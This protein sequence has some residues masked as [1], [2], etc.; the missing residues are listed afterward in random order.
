MCLH[1]HYTY[2]NNPG[3]ENT[4]ARIL[5]RLKQTSPFKR[6]DKRDSETCQLPNAPVA[7]ALRPQRSHAQDATSCLGCNI[8]H[9]R[10]CKRAP[11]I[12]HSSHLHPANDPKLDQL[13]RKCV[14][15]KSSGGRLKVMGGIELASVFDL[16]LERWLTRGSD[17]N[18]TLSDVLRG[19]GQASHLQCLSWVAVGPKKQGYSNRF[20]ANSSVSVQT[21]G[22]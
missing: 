22:T 15:A 8:L 17:G 18:I 10:V 12:F 6:A 2:G 3:A 14:L 11:T 16:R 19:T 5:N 13:P 1:E 20:R 4:N 7:P 21:F 9:H